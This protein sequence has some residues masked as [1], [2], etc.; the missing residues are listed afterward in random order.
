MNKQL[1]IKIAGFSIGIRAEKTEYLEQLEKFYKGFVS[2][3]KKSDFLIGIEDRTEIKTVPTTKYV[4]VIRKN[5]HYKVV[6]ENRKSYVFGDIF[7]E[8]K[9]CSYYNQYN[10]MIIPFF[11]SFLKSCVHILLEKKNGVFL[12]ASAV[13]LKGKGYVFSGPSTSGKTTIVNMKKGLDII[14]EEYVT[15]CKH[16]GY[17]SIFET[18]WCGRH[19]QQTKLD[20]IFFLKKDKNLK[21][22]KLSTAESFMEILSKR[23][24]TRRHLI[25]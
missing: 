21:F 3:D 24:N 17:Y 7:P 10:P 2:N 5:N 11:D 18:P 20:K 14:S 9:R 8:E 19:N 25:F 6:N 13:N 12:H 22:Q 16:N 4:S 1:N 23:M 15:V